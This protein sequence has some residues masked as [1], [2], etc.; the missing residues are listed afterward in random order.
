[1]HIDQKGWLQSEPGDPVVL[2]VPTERTT[3][4]VGGKPLGLAWHWTADAVNEGGYGDSVALAKS[5]AKRP[6]PGEASASWN[7]L[8]DRTGAIVQSASFLSG[9]WHVGRPGIVAD[10]HF[11]NVNAATI[12]IEL[13]NAGRLT[14]VGNDW[15]GWPFYK[16]G[17]VDGQRVRAP[18]FGVDPRFV[19]AKTRMV[20]YPD[21]TFQHVTWK[22]GSFD[23]YTNEQEVS[24]QAIVTALAA[25][26]GWKA[27]A[28]RYGHAL[29]VPP[30]YK[31]DPGP[32]WLGAGG[33]LEGILA[34]VFA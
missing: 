10:Q 15:V 27:D 6:A 29:F 5:I 3:K 17:I 11:A 2:H 24:A 31:E 25:F 26:F 4:L 9:T 34:R 28:F 13:E 32:G 7:A 8:V 18:R 21:T 20:T 1:M 30:S 12:G 23:A 33:M 19:V 22:A 16:A 14:K